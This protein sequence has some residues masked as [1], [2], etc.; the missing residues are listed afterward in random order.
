MKLS[1][2]TDIHLNFLSSDARQ[3][4]YTA[5]LKTQCDAV[6]ISGDIA[7]ANTLSETL[8]EMVHALNKPIYFVLGN[9]DYY[10]GQINLVRET[11]TKLLR[12]E[13][14]LCWLTGSGA[15]HLTE[16]VILLGQ[17]GWADG[18]LGDYNHSR[19]E[20]NDSTMIKDFF[21]EKLLSRSRLLKKMQALADRDALQLENEIHEVNKQGIKKIIVLTHVPPFREACL[22]NG[23]ASQEFWLPFFSS[24]ATGNVLT[25]VAKMYIDIQFLVLCG[26]TH[27]EAEFKPL[28][29]LI[30]KTGGAEYYQPIV[31]EL[32]SL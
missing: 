27:S 30:V 14:L 10:H 23:K 2:L 3:L 26:H 32:I 28:P 31:Q 8:L 12:N 22:H 25:K 24:K 29:N 5:I 17:D 4:F 13:R 6:L 16:D 21:Q 19:V 18:R 11:M 7:T 1:W 9:H 15:Q 20:I